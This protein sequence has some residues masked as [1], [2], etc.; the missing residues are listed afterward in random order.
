MS[1]EK[2]APL[3]WLAD[4]MEAQLRRE[5]EGW[6]PANLSTLLDATPCPRCGGTGRVV[7]G[8]TTA[9]GVEFRTEGPCRCR[10]TVAV[11]TAV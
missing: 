4:A 10:A 5:L 6:E 9:E 11:P 8:G 1:G 3:A 2:E 7:D